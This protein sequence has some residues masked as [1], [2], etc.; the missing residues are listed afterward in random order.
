[1]RTCAFALL[2]AMVLALLLAASSADA[3]HDWPEY[4]GSFDVAAALTEDGT[5]W[6]APAD[7]A[8]AL[9]TASGCPV[10][11]GT[12][13]S[14]TAILNG[15]QRIRLEGNAA[16]PAVANHFIANGF[17][18]HYV[19]PGVLPGAPASHIHERP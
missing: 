2:P 9:A 12:V 11:L 15:I 1:M 10:Y 7:Q 5:L 6:L 18:I 16:S 14:V 17:F 13:S 3:A 19:V 4:E 8:A